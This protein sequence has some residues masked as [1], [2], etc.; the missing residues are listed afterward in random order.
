MGAI[1]RYICRTTLG[2]FLIVLV[3]ITAIF[4]VVQALRYIDL[5]TS[6]GQTVLIFIRITSLVIPFL[7]TTIAPIALTIAALHTL[8]KLSTDSELTVMSAAGLST[9]HLFRSFLL[10]ALAVSLLVLAIATYFGPKGLR[11]M[12]DQIAKVNAD[13]INTVLK[14]NHFTAIQ[15]GVTVFIRERQPDGLLRGILIDDQ[16]NPNERTTLIADT[17]TMLELNE[18]PI[19][20]LRSGVLQRRNINNRGVT[21]VAFDSYAFDLS[22]FATGT[23]ISRYSV[24]ER[25][26]SELLFPNSEDPNYITQKRQYRSELHDRILASL[27][28][29]TFM[30]IALIYFR[31]PRTDRKN[32]IYSIAN[33]AGWIALQRIVGVV[34]NILGTSTP[35]VLW[36][37]YAAIGAVFAL[38]LFFIATDARS[39]AAAIPHLC[40]SGAVA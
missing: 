25:Y 20:S 8:N 17:G 3:S 13:V 29:L 6:R 12:R 9:W 32:R 18:R 38:G 15:S 11:M 10:T 36:L 40:R 21:M 23:Q 16:R 26:L 22:Q 30:L 19:L 14:P 35:L 2:S 7:V 27:Y 5:V 28:P 24:R 33:A 31:A 34:C 39:K 4:W 1:S 37:P